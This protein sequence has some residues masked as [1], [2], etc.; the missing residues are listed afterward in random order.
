MAPL[1]L[2]ANRPARDL[3]VPVTRISEILHGRR[4]ISAGTAL[5]LAR[6]FGTTAQ[7]RM[8][9]QTVHDLEVA[10]R[11]SAPAIAREVLPRDAA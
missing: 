6:C 5:R 4:G 3:R 8:N 7:F 10:E 1:E 9:L 11:E 2:S